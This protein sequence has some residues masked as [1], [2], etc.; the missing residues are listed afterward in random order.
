MVTRTSQGPLLKRLVRKWDRLWTDYRMARRKAAYRRKVGPPASKTPVFV[1]GSQ[2]SGTD[3]AI[4]ALDRSLE[5]DRFDEYDDRA[6]AD[7]RIKDLA[8][9]RRLIADSSAGFVVFKPVSDSHR[10]TE[11]LAEHPDGKVIWLYRRYQ[12]VANSAVERWGDR[13]REWLVDL[14]AGGGNWGTRQWNAEKITAECLA[15]VRRVC[16]QDPSPH[17]AAALFWYMRNRTFFEQQLDN[18][19]SVLLV[20]YEDA[21]T[22]SQ[23]EFARIC[24]FLGIDSSLEMTDKVFSSSV[25]KREFPAIARPIEDLCVAMLERLDR[26]RAAAV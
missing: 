5:V 4:K 6:F 15:E 19:L 3:M 10:V 26:V 8:T 25:G 16:P 12:D 1:V 11:L 13:T 21:V 24:R 22:R 17:E 2:R 14:L 18:S 20:R 23:E 7:T 9:R